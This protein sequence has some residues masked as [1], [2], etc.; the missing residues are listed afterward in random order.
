MHLQKIPF[1]SAQ[2]FSE[3]FL[4]YIEQQPELTP[5]YGRFP[6]VESFGEQI[7][8][9]SSAFPATTRAIL[10]ESLQQQYKDIKLTPAVEQNITA[11][12]EANTFTVTTGHQLSVFTGPLYFVFKIATVIKACRELKARYPKHHFVPVYWMASEDHDYDEIK[13]FRLYGKKYTWETEQQGGVGRFHTKD[14]K[15]L[16]S[17]IPGDIK[18]FKDAYT[19][20]ATLADA[21][22][23]YV[24]ALFGAEGLVVIDADRLEL[25]QLLKPVMQDDLFAHTSFRIVSETNQKLEALGFHPQ[26]NPR[27]INFFYLDTQLRSRIEQ[28]AEGFTVVDTPLRF[29]REEIL[30]KLESTPEVFS[31][32]VILRPVYQE[33]ILPNLAYVGGPAELVYWLELKGV[34]EHFRVP[35]P[36]LLPRN[37]GLVIDGPTSRK[38]NHTRLRLDSFFQTKND[39]FKHWVTQH[40]EHDLSLEKTAKSMEVLFAEVQAR[41]AKIDPTL[42]PMTAAHAARMQKM[43]H[44]IEQKMM[45]AEKRRQSDGLRQ[46]EAVKDALFPNGG[47]QERTDNFLNFFQTDPSFIRQLIAHFDPFDFQFHVM[48]YD[49]QKGTSKA[50]S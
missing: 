14:F 28:Q 33:I 27:E 15:K 47:L 21:V 39:L 3:F 16:L 22:R 31:P 46:V 49:D 50:V 12:R 45:R 11:L 26:V 18:I 40:S 1:R 30:Q 4:K 13:S 19:Q 42:G 20:C 7:K 36:I 44:A 35:F 23:Q 8:E 29:T 17:E 9:K 43:I 32:N 38:M 10:V 24:N 34:F 25:K 2:A 41:S 48:T 6:S 37:F 5:F